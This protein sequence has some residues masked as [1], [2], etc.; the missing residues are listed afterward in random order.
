MRSIDQL[1]DACTTAWDSTLGPPDIGI[2]VRTVYRM[3]LTWAG[4][5][6]PARTHCR[7][8]SR[9]RLSLAPR[10]PE[11]RLLYLVVAVIVANGARLR[12]LGAAEIGSG[13]FAFELRP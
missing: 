2:R 13:D 10:G 5:I 7:R 11:P 12:P 8:R 6:D 9:S 1:S 3:P 4:W